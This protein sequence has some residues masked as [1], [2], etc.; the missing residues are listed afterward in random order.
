MIN[1]LDLHLLKL[2]ELLE[3]ANT[4]IRDPGTIKMLEAAYVKL[5]DHLWYLSER[6]VLLALFSARVADHDK[7]EMANYAIQGPNPS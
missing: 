6:L 3:K 7:K 1:H 2:L 5:K 4:K